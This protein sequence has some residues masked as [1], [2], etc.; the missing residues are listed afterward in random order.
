MSEQNQQRGEALFD[1]LSKNKKLRRRR[2]IRNVTL[3]IVLAAVAGV[4]AVGMLRQ[5]VER[6][7]ADAEAEVQMHTVAPGTLHTTVSGSGVLAEVDLEQIQVPEG[8]TVLEVMVE[9]GDAVKQG[10]LLASV[11]MATVMTTLS[12]LQEQLD[13]LDDDINAAKGETVSATITAGLTGRVKRILAQKDM[14]VSACMAEHGALAV[15]SLDGYMAVELETQA[16]NKGDTVT[17]T[18]ADGETTL[19][20]TVETAAGGRAT[21]LVT[22]NGPQ[23]DEEVT[24]T[25]E[26]GTEVGKGKLYIHN[27]LAVTGYAGT[28]RSVNTR[29]NAYVNAWSGLFSLKNTSF[30]ANYD[31]LLRNRA[32]LEEDLLSLLT[33]Y[34]DG[35][36]L[37]PMDGAI[38]SVQFDNEETAAPSSSASAAASSPYAAYY[39]TTSG[40]AAAASSSAAA[41]EVEGTAVLKLYPNRQMSIAIAIDE[42]DI[43]ALKEGQEAQVEVSSV[44]QERFTGTVT[45]IS[46]VADTSSGVTQYSAEV[47]LDKQSGMLSGMTASVDVKIQGVENAL[48]IPVDALHQTST[49]RYVYTAYDPE[50]QQYGGMVEVT[51]GMQS[52]EFVEILSGLHA[53]D[54]VYYTEAPQNIFAAF[55]AMGGGMMGPM[56]NRGG[57]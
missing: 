43:M 31:T 41:E 7:F 39:G 21:V 3:V 30:S 51:T 24:V 28:I 44:S 50:L 14:D 34:R 52:D 37:A 53:G 13:D 22:D 35:A 17:V 9:A 12:D 32:E 57:R 36:L 1:E 8:V 2:L 29:E 6:R 27:P 49:I 47:T 23:Y 33:I 19:S 25:R 11:D 16:L 55:A 26:D 5:N 38:S 4:I 54:V 10:D 42:T 56:P 48:L 18:R 45:K 46:K 15:L 20:G 40:T